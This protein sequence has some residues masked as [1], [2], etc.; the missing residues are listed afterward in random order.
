MANDQDKTKPANEE[1]LMSMIEQIIKD[2]FE[3]YEPPS[4]KE[5]EE[6]EPETEEE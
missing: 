5:E 3:G 1:E 6:E 4:S 2:V